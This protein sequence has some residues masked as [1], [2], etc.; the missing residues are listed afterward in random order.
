MAVLIL[1]TSV[2]K[3]MRT[4]IAIMMLAMLASVSSYAQV[5]SVRGEIIDENGSPLV[6]STVVLLDP[7]DSTMQYFGVSNTNGRFEIKNIREGRYLMQV[8]FIGYESLYK[9]M[10]MPAADNG[11]L[12]YI[13][14]SPKTVSLD[15]V[16]VQGERIPLRIKDDTLEYDAKAFK[17]KPDAV[18]EDLLKKMPGIEVDRAG[19]IKALGENVNNVL[20]DGKE[21]FGND[22]KVATK[23]LPAD[24]IDKVQLYNKKSDESEFT[25]IDD[26]SRNQTLNLVLDEDKKKG[27]FGDLMA[28]GGTDGH[29]QANGKAYRFSDKNQMAA[30]GMMNNINNFGFS[31]GDYLTFSGGI[32]NLSSGSVG[33]TLGGG[34]LPINFGET[35][36][37]YSSSGALGFNYSHSRGKGQRVFISYI[38]NGSKREL[39][40]LTRTTSYRETGSF[41]QEENTSQVKRDT[42]HAI[43]F[44]IRNLFRETN[45]LIVNGNISINNGF[46]PLTSSM[47]SYQDNLLVNSIDRESSYLSDRLS[48]NINGSF[49]KKLNEGKTVL[50]F[51]GVGSYSNS[52]AETIFSNVTTFEDPASTSTISQFQDNANRSLA[53]N[54]GLALTQQI[55]GALFMEATMNA[56]TTDESL[57]RRQGNSADSDMLIDTLSPEFDR[58]DKWLKP[59]LRFRRNTDKSGIAL[60]L[61]YHIGSYGT[62]LWEDGPVERAY[63]FLQPSLIW[64]YEYKSGRRLSARYTSKSN[65]PSANQLLPIVNNFNSLSLYYGN[66]NLKPEYIHSAQLNWW[67]FDQFSFTSLLSSIRMTYTQNKINYSRQVDDN[68]GQIVTLVNVM[69]DL[70][71]SGNIDFSTP[72]RA[73]GV[74]TNLS[75]DESYNNGINIVNGLE[76]EISNL[77]HRLSFSVD[78]RKKEKWD[79]NT[80]VGVTVTDARYS[81]QSNLDNLYYNLSWFGEIRYT[82]TDKINFSTTAD[83]TNYTARGFDNSQIVPLIGAEITFFFLKNNRAALTLSGVDLLNRNTGIERVSELNY[84]RETRSNIIGRYVMLSFKW[85]LNKFGGSDQ[86]VKVQMRKR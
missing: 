17:I 63:S 37:G 64:D 25:G 9:M 12:G 71:L 10:D 79:I 23:N 65:L 62:T 21:F 60:G 44:G 16:T 7:A 50:K 72:I 52:N 67:I 20:V 35:I 4:V 24:A 26:G 36:N 70:T 42:S 68:L 49:L 14:L 48:G 46:N 34:S 2:S 18:V 33:I 15:E 32:A 30:I 76:N 75:I 51:F 19:N 78:N 59:A 54:G 66:R 61:E 38:G 83:V 56:G 6:S 41:F 11:N 80:G 28:G 1:L 43:N 13:P 86:G 69:S 55:A 47:Y 40:D 85:K 58:F 45:N 27:V 81:I 82:P 8:A 22:P 5:S 39:D 77:T 73:L 57:V 3:K 84:L 29:Y 31:F 74:K 53:Y